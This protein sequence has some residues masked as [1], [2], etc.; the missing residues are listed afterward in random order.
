MLWK[1]TEDG[2]T[3]EKNE[4]RELGQYIP[5]HYH[6]HM[7]ADKNRMGGFKTAI[8]H[9]VQPDDTVLELG[10]GTGVLSWFAAQTARKVYS[11]EYNMDLVDASRR[12]LSHNKNGERVEVIHGDAFVFTPPE[13]V[14]VVICEMLH[15]GL[16]REKQM[17]VINAFKMRY[18]AAFPGLPLPIFIPMGVL[19]AM[20]PVCHD[21]NYMGYYAPAIM[22]SDPY[23]IHPETVELG[24]PTI[25]HQL[26]YDQP[27]PLECAWEGPI[28]IKQAGRLNALRFITKN[29]LAAAGTNIIDWH[30]QHI[31]VPLAKELEV[32]AGQTLSISLS[33]PAGAPLSALRP[34]INGNISVC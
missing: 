19:Q 28:T 15:T 9:I 4:T 10:S 14:H 1:N 33:Y 26:I 21:F 34:V 27:Y 20:Q 17:E 23:S 22:F 6:Y 2:I 11:V 32:T 16:L 25:Y 3:L 18:Q 31:I 13:P 24:D 30:T 29:V 7:L 5:L 12:I 8:E